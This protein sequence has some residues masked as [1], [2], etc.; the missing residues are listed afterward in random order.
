ME[1]GPSTSIDNIDAKISGL[2]PLFTNA[3][4]KIEDRE[5]GETISGVPK[6]QVRG[7]HWY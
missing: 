6:D 4:L 1:G 5:T 2:L 3:E 7:F